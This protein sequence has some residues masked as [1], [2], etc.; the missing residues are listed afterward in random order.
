MTKKQFYYNPETMYLNEKGYPVYKL[1]QKLVHRYTV[2]K[3]IRKLEI[4][5]EVHHVNGDKKDYRLSNLI[6]LHKEDHKKLEEQIRKDRN[7]LIAYE[8]IILLALYFL[9]ANTGIGS[10]NVNMVVGF[11]LLLGMIMPA[12]PK[13][14]RRVLFF[15]GVLKRNK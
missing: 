8:L 2:E 14:L 9:G 3:H 7:L 5:E 4:G 6:I 11:L 13:T 12:F 15:L 10:V 1:S